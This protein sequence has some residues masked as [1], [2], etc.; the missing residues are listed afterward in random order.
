M[1]RQV[2]IA[3]E[4]F[5]QALPVL[6][7]FGGR[8]ELPARPEQSESPESLLQ[9]LPALQQDALVAMGSYGTAP[10]ALARMPP[11]APRT[12]GSLGRQQ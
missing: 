11:A 10:S 12:G 8:D 7:G 1:H 6:R 9:S 5:R 2:E 3:P 4:H